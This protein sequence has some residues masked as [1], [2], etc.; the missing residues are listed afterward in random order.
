MDLNALSREQLETWLIGKGLSVF[1]APF[2]ERGVDGLELEVLCECLTQGEMASVDEEYGDIGSPVKRR[3]LQKLL[4][5]AFANGIPASALVA[6][7]APPP[8]GSP[9][10]PGRSRGGRA[11]T[12]AA[13]PAPTQQPGAPPPSGLPL[14]G[15]FTVS[16]KELSVGDR[17]RGWMRVHLP[18]DGAASVFIDVNAAARSG[19]RTIARSSMPPSRMVDAHAFVRPLVAL[20]RGW[21][22][23]WQRD[24]GEVFYTDGK[25]SQ[26]HMPIEATVDGVSARATETSAEGMYKVTLHN[27][28]VCTA[29]GI[30]LRA[31]CT[32]HYDE[33]FAAPRCVVVGIDANG[34]VERLVPG[35]VAA[36]DIIEGVNKR[37]IVGMGLTQ[38]KSWIRAALGTGTLVLSMRRRRDATRGAP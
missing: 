6:A 29:L 17:D 22:R 35:V 30:D 28:T 23:G 32:P 26:W 14:A 16:S 20:Q 2:A 19:G 37:I 27:V 38:A 5:E 15:V 31:L 25:T 33:S 4:M 24:T 11:R 8:S 9:P 36:G 1:A 3:K 34:V 18:G 12:S 10:P 13:G 21:K 7:V